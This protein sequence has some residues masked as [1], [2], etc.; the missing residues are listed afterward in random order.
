V[1]AWIELLKLVGQI[2]VDVVLPIVRA[3][4]TRDNAKI[5][6]AVDAALEGYAAGAAAHDASEHAGH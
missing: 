6:A 2:G 5:K 1:S 3:L 4:S